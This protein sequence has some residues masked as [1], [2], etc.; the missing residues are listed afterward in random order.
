[1]IVA[2]KC[3][4]SLFIQ[5]EEY[6]NLYTT[7]SSDIESYTSDALLYFYLF[8]LQCAMLLVTIFD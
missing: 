2:S 5:T 8:M 4:T 3:P 7:L 6:P 1:M